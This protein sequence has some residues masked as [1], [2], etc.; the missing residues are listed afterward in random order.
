[1][2]P[3]DVA[4]RPLAPYV[5]A[6]AHVACARACAHSRILA[7]IRERPFDVQSQHSR[8]SQTFP[9]SRLANE[10]KRRNT[11][12]T[13]TSVNKNCWCAKR[14]EFEISFGSTWHFSQSVEWRR[15]TWRQG[16]ASGPD[17]NNSRRSTTTQRMSEHRLL[18]PAII[19]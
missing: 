9:C 19:C 1:M 10:M 14:A 17:D 18:F 12:R 8:Q 4:R 13:H 5:H 16:A 15:V 2:W 3:C 7:S 6:Q 11:E